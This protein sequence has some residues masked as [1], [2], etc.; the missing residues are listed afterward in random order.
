[1]FGA[2]MLRP[3]ALTIPDV[4]VSGRLNG[5]PIATTGSPTFAVD[6][7]A[8]EIGCSCEAGALTWITAI[9]GN[10]ITST[11]QFIET[12]DTFTPGQTITLTV[13][14]GGSTQQVKLTLGTRPN[15]PPSTG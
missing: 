7:S 8:N 9:N 14:R 4:T 3:T 2:V 6:E 1:M 13:K 5:L 11:Q 15:S 10:A 12:V